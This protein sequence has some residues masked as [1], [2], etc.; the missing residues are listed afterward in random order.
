MKKLLAIVL[1]VVMALGM[2]SMAAAEE[3][4]AAPAAKFCSKCGSKLD[5]NG[6]C[7][8]CK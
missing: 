7:P 3:K 2:V 5:E 8:N 4:P 6:N 1:A